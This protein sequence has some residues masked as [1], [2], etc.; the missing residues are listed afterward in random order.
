MKKKANKLKVGDVILKGEDT[1][2]AY[3]SIVIFIDT[4]AD[5]IIEVI[6]E[7]NKWG[8]EPKYC[9]SSELVT[10]IGGIV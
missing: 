8:A 10:V 9:E 4:R 1:S 3:P 7:S 2:G 5:G 6:S